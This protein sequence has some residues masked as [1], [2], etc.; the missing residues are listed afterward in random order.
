MVERHKERSLLQDFYALFGHEY[1]A[2]NVTPDGAWILKN[3]RNSYTGLDGVADHIIYDT[4]LP[5]Q[6]TCTV[7]GGYLPFGPQCFPCKAP[8]IPNT[9]VCIPIH[10]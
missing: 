5:I 10:E 8:E 4:P 9:D 6:D 3:E 2:P 1:C 7:C